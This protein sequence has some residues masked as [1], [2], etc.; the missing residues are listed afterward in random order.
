MHDGRLVFTSIERG[1]TTLW[2]MD[3]DGGRRR[4]LLRNPFREEYP[5]AF[6]GGIAYVGTTPMATEL[7]VTS[8]D[9]DGRRVVVSSVDDAPIAVS[10]DGKSFV[11]AFNRRLWRTSADGGQRRQ[12]TQQA[13]SAPVY[14]PN[15]DRIAFITSDA[16][17]REDN[18]LVIMDAEGSRI[19]WSSPAPAQG[20]AHCLRWTTDGTALLL[21][22]WGH[23]VWL[24]PL[25][26]RPKQLT[27]FDD[28]IWSFDVSSANALFVARGSVT[29]DA[30]LITGFR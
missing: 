29:R 7:C 13:A 25:D 30:V 9:G 17:Q 19:V 28:S 10:P 23:N 11:Y 8:N 22:N 2:I 16:E 14:S 6:S 20:G 24:Y 5:V 4:Q 1:T 26:G 21:A 15:G 3:A 18:R 27:N 12:L